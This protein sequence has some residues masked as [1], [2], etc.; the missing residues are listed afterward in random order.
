MRQMIRQ[1]RESVAKG[2]RTWIGGVSALG[3]VLALACGGTTITAQKPCAPGESIACVS[4]AGCSAAQTCKADGGGYDA[5][6]CFEGT[7]G[8][9][10][11]AGDNHGAPDSPSGGSTSD[12]VAF[13]ATVSVS[14]ASDASASLYSSADT[15]QDDDA[16][17]SDAAVPDSGDAGPPCPVGPF[18]PDIG[19]SCLQPGQTCN[20]GVCGVS[21]VKCFNGSWQEADGPCPP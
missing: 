20:Y 19:S 18:A 9:S 16:S 7:S 1:A 2:R 17:P 4:Q 10:G 14:S 6:L 15:S 5:C 12:A 13:D 3:I 11:D 8:A 21:N